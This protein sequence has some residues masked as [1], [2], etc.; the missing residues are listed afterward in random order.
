MSTPSVG[1][2][3]YTLGKSFSDGRVEGVRIE[4]GIYPAAKKKK[5][6]GRCR[7]MHVKNL[8]MSQKH[9][10]FSGNKVTNISDKSVAFYLL[11]FEITGSFPRFFIFFLSIFSK[12][13]F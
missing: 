9:I 7:Q 2:T 1:G 10:H 12:G 13:I 8:A 3:G 11:R 4:P 5:K 6:K